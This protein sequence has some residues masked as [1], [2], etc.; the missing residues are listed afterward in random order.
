MTRTLLAL[1][2][3]A[4]FISSAVAGIADSPLPGLLPGAPTYH[5]YSVP[6]VICGGNMFTFFVCT[7]TDTAAQQVAVEMFGNA[8]GGPYNDA[9][10]ESVSAQP[11]AT[12]RLGTV[13]PTNDILGF[14]GVSSVISCP[15]P[16]TASARILSTSRKL[17]C[18]AFVGDAFTVPPQTSWQLTIVAKV[19]QKAAN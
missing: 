9:A 10:L 2:L 13:Q 4:S 11:G 5:L 15:G 7:S 16:G 14:N 12:V 1:A 6:G 18:T 8:G 17:M 19:K 3:L